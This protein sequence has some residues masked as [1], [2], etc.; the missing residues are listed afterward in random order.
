MKCLLLASG[1]GTRLYPITENVAKGLLPYK[2]KPLI[3][4]LVEK[5]P[6]EMELYVNTNKRFESQFLNWQK[7]LDREVVLCVEPV[8][9]KQ[10]S[11]GAVG[12]L[13]Y[14]VSENAICDDLIIFASDNYF[15]FDVSGFL[16]AFDGIH[17]L[18]AVYDIT[19]KEAARQFGVVKLNGKKV[20]EFAEK[21]E[22]PESSLIATACYI[23]PSHVIPIL[24]Q[25]CRSGKRDN[26]GDFIKYLVDVDL[27]NAYIF[28]ELWFDI[29]SVWHKLIK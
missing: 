8:F 10:Q 11:L 7:S 16:S 12:S 20:A 19:D 21:P 17:P 1:F 15:E 5:I 4:H 13:E 25:F 9:N 22:K 26:L 29:G 2:G 3:N 28:K 18:I 24:H 14:W 23:F 6:K 27:V